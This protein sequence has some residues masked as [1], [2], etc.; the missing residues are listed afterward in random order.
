MSIF[1]AVA[2]MIERSMDPSLKTQFSEAHLSKRLGEV[3]RMICRARF[4]T[5]STEQV[6]DSHGL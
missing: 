3:F 6:P 2:A 1:G 5:I 4:I